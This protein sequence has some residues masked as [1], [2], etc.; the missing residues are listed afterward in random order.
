MAYTMKQLMEE[1][2]ELVEQDQTDVAV[3]TFINDVRARCGARYTPNA[4]TTGGVWVIDPMT[5]RSVRSDAA[6]E[7]LGICKA[8]LHRRGQER[9]VMVMRV[10]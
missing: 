10:S 5:A 7:A 3:M 1:T 6:I 4:W 9:D 2:A 8:K